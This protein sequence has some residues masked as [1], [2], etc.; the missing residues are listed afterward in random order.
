M[1]PKNTTWQT[2][3]IVGAVLLVVGL[4]AFFVTARAT[5]ASSFCPRCHEMQP[6]YQA[7]TQGPHSTQ[8]QCVDAT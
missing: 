4:V 1:G 6:H 8:A 3:G 7:W 5:D 2:W